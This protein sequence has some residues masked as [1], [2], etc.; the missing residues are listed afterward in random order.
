MTE[1]S[2]VIA[3]KPIKSK[4]FESFLFGFGALVEQ[5]EHPHFGTEC[6]DAS[7]EFSKGHES[8]K[9]NVEARD[10]TQKC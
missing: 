8:S 9:K 2:L 10:S 7:V 4:E 3:R 5:Y 1:I 6:F